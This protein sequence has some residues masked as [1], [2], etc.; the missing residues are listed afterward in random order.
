MRWFKTVRKIDGKFVANYDKKFEYRIGETVREKVDYSETDTCGGGIHISG[1]RWAL[2]FG[3][4]WENCALL[5]LE[6]DPSHIFVSTDTDGKVRCSE[7]LV[8]REVP[9]EEWNA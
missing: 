5:E 2:E 3:K 4:D 6:A 9:K 8:V 1:K 7:A